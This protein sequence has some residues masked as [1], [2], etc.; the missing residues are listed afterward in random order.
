MANGN[1]TMTVI[2]WRTRKSILTAECVSDGVLLC[3]PGWGTK[4][5]A[6]RPKD[7]LAL[8][9]IVVPVVQVLNRSRPAVIL[10]KEYRAGIPATFV[11]QLYIGSN[12]PYLARPDY[13]GVGRSWAHAFRAL[14]CCAGINH[15]HQLAP[16]GWR[17]D[18]QR[19]LYPRARPQ[20]VW[21]STAAGYIIP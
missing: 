8:R 13:Q 19:I 9:Q 14:K 16:A 1:Y 11:L 20:L 3:V 7:P 10:K 2:G 4:R 18:Q 21:D 5:Y 12:R 15:L 6:F 17:L